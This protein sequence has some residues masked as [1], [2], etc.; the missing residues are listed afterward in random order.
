[1]I[2][3]YS[4]LMILLVMV[5]IVM[6]IV[7]IVMRMICVAGVIFVGWWSDIE[8]WVLR[9]ETVWSPHKVR[10]SYRHNRPVL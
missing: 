7:T 5:V 1:M 4:W 6:M 10:V 2:I 3:D 9:E 8:R